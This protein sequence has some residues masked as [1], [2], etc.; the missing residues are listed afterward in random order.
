MK[1]YFE[2]PNGVAVTVDSNDGVMVKVN[3]TRNTLEFYAPAINDADRIACEA[4]VAD[5]EE[6]EL[7]TVLD[8]LCGDVAEAVA[9]A[10]C[11]NEGITTRRAS[12]A[13]FL[14]SKL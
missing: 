8:I 10:L 5:I 6:S 7:V 11:G 4:I 12:L 13:G 14:I 2:Y 1:K 9:F 3:T